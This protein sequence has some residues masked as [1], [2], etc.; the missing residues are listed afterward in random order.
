MSFIKKLSFRRCMTPQVEC[1]SNAVGS[2]LD[3]AMTNDSQKLPAPIQLSSPSRAYAPAEVVIT[4]VR[5]PMGEM[6]TLLLKLVVAMFFANLL[7]VA[8]AFVA[9]LFFVGG[10]AGLQS[11]GH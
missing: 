7:I 9:L 6:V 10:V 8:V 2:L 1:G 3:S 4:G 11:I 5:I